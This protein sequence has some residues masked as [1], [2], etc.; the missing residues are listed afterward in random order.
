MNGQ[1]YLFWRKDGFINSKIIQRVDVSR[2]LNRWRG[3][4][5]MDMID[6]AGRLKG[7]MVL[8]KGVT[9]LCIW[10]EKAYHKTGICI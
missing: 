3:V 2:R 8:I 9:R 7:L 4:V 1:G 5:R 6:T 10:K